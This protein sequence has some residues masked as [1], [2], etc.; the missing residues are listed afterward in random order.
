VPDVRKATLAD[1]ELLSEALARAFDDDPIWN[2]LFPERRRHQ[3]ARAFLAYELKHHYLR[4]DETW[5]TAEGVRGAAVWMPPGTWRQSNLQT[6]R[7]LPTMV[8]LLS[9]RLPIAFRSL[10]A[11][12]AAHPPGEHYYLSILGTDPTYQGQGVASAC[13]EPVL[14]RCDEQGIGAYLESSKEKNV[15]FYN[16]HGFEVTRELPLPGNGPSVW[17]MWREPRA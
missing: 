13:L 11:I 9:A 4:H 14:D 10:L 3:R 6:L 7:S 12:E 16:R 1:I 17:L 15:P 5:T 8:R 2:F